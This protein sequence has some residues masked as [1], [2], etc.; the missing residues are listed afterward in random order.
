MVEIVPRLALF[1]DFLKANPDIRIVGPQVGGRLAELVGI[2]GLDPSRLVT[3][4]TRANIVYQPRATGCGF[5]NVQES[6][7]LSLLYRDYIERTLPPQPRNRLILIRRSGQRKFSKQK[8]IEGALN[9]TAAD[10]NLTYTLFPD[11]P[12]PSLNDTMTMF[13]SAVI[14]VAPC[15]AGESNM[16][17]SEPG[18]YV[19][20]GVCNLP[21]VNLCFQRLAHVLEHH[22]HG[23]TSRGGCEA[24]VDVAASHIDA[25]VRE[26]LRLWSL[27]H[28]E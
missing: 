25:A 1:V 28:R 21:H 23:V 14:I 22:W 17:F 26:Y 19:V 6:Q 11:N 4:S 13:H 16:I 20:E 5:A 18:T 24:V 12:I 27:S 3:G 2:L 15:G 10:F 8:E 7:T 9:R